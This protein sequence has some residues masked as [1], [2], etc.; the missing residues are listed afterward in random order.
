MQGPSVTILVGPSSTKYTLPKTLA[1]YFSPVLRRAFNGGFK[2]AQEQTIHFAEETCRDVELVLQWM[3]SNG[4]TV[5]L[6]GDEA[7]NGQTAINRWID[8]ALIGDMLDLSGSGTFGALMIQNIITK[9]LKSSGY[10]NQLGLIGPPISGACIRKAI[11]LPRKHPV[12]SILADAA[13]TNYIYCLRK[14]TVGTGYKLRQELD[15][16]KSFRSDLQ[17]AVEQVYARAI[18]KPAK[19]NSSYRTVSTCKFTGVEIVINL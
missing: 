19:T 2:E 6:D 13:A 7:N 14:G 5:E 9:S 17:L 10:I 4:T 1:E 3:Y 15:D 11:D 12:R 16:L 18:S 8:F